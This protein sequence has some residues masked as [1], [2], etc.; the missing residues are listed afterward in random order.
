MKSLPDIFK[1]G[2]ILKEP[3]DSILGFITESNR[4]V[5]KAT[6]RNGDKLS[7]TE[8]PGGKRVY[9]FSTKK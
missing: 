8:Y 1:S 5:I 4:K 2:N 7:V 6:K 9:T 3:G